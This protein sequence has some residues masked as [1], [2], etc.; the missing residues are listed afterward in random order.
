MLILLRMLTPHG[1]K[2]TA[3]A[4]VILYSV[5]GASGADRIR[6]REKK[7]ISLPYYLPIIVEIKSFPFNVAETN[8]QK[9]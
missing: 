3:V 4:P 5:M 6:L 9:R 1:Y 7:R 2:I 8:S